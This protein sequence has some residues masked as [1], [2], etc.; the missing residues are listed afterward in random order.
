MARLRFDH[1][2][3]TADA[4]AAAAPGWPRA[5]V[6]VQ[7]EQVLQQNVTGCWLAR[8]DV[9]AADGAA[10]GGGGNTVFFPSSR[11]NCIYGE[12]MVVGY[13]GTFPGLALG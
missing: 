10:D 8:D 6:H 13:V 11:H 5:F 9:V 1:R 2:R 4:F 12:R 3:Q 7:R